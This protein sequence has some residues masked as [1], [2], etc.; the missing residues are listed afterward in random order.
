MYG[1]VWYVCMSVC[2]LQWCVCVCLFRLISSHWTKPLELKLQWLP[3]SVSNV[4]NGL[5]TS[6]RK[7]RATRGCQ[8]SLVHYGIDLSQ[9]SPMVQHH[10]LLEITWFL[11]IWENPRCFGQTNLDFLSIAFSRSSAK[12]M[13]ILPIVFSSDFAQPK[14]PNMRPQLPAISIASKQLQ[15]LS[16]NF[17]V[18]GFG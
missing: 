13:L 15:S 18:V 8:L 11:I 7:F 10:V 2:V 16:S 1:M 3:G 4:S 14:E 6:P 17:R 5:L 9:N 12:P